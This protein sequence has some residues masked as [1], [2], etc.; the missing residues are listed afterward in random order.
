MRALLTVTQVL[1][2]LLLIFSLTYLMP[3]ACALY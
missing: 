2:R 1:G 3:F